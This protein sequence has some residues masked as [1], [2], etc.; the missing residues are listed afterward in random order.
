MKRVTR[1]EFAQIKRWLIVYR[2]LGSVQRVARRADRSLKTIVQ[3]KNSKT[4]SD[5][6]EQCKAQHPPVK[7]S[8]ADDVLWLH[9]KT[10]RPSRKDYAKPH[11]AKAAIRE[12]LNEQR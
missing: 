11:S 9:D 7:Y 4:H 1:Q 2:G 12:L 8:L 10:F 3:I 6:I 5:Y